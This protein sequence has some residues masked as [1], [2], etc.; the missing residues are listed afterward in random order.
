MYTNKPKEI[1]VLAFRED[2]DKLR[3]RLTNAQLELARQLFSLERFGNTDGA[4]IDE[5]APIYII[6]VYNMSQYKYIDAI[7]FDVFNKEKAND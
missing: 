6:L 3:L 2:V 4:H 1:G 7:N 5:I